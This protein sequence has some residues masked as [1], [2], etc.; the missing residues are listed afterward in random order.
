MYSNLSLHQTLRSFLKRSQNDYPSLSNE[1]ITHAQRVLTTALDILSDFSTSMATT[2][3]SEVI[4]TFLKRMNVLDRLI[5]P[6]DVQ[7]NADS[8]AVAA[9][10]KVV[11]E[12][13]RGSTTVHAQY[14]V[15]MLLTH[16]DFPL[17]TPTEDVQTQKQVHLSTLRAASSSDVEA[18]TVLLVQLRQSKF[19]GR[20]TPPSI[21]LP[22]VFL[23]NSFSARS[24]KKHMTDVARY[25]LQ[26]GIL[27]ARKR[28][29]LTSVQ[30]PK[31]Q[32][33]G[34]LR[35]SALLDSLTALSIIPSER[36]TYCKKKTMDSFET[37]V[38]DIIDLPWV[39]YSQ[40]YEYTAC[41]YRYYLS[42][43]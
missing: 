20:Y 23:E 24:S 2:S 9:L 39:S 5:T 40:I 19:P 33:R 26:D 16:A 38:P 32:S 36:K 14:V 21:P 3:T 4:Q 37:H 35:P 31:E 29:V 34:V 13:E 41:P 22:T 25:V 1:E 10:L 15:P 42:R 17:P 30:S 11:A 27:R 6:M 7:S 43:V 28:I 18:D 12:M 8:D